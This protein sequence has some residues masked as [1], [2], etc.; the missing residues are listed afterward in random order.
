MP[1]VR[2]INAIVCFLLRYVDCV[3]NVLLSLCPYGLKG[4]LQKIILTHRV[5]YCE[6]YRLVTYLCYAALQSE[7]L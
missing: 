1:S 7:C 3:R 6:K 5:A 2:S 4:T